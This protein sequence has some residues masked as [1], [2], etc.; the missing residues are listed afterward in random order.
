MS[1]IATI[2]HLQMQNIKGTGDAIVKKSFP[3][4]NKHS[5]S[6]GFVQNEIGHVTIIEIMDSSETSS[7]QLLLQPLGIET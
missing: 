7:L 4:T 1:I 3:E 5:D 6:K 2:A